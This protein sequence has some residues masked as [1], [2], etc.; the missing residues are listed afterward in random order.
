MR[1]VP[2]PTEPSE[3]GKNPSDSEAGRILSA[4]PHV[5][6]RSGGHLVQGEVQGQELDQD[7]QGA[8]TA[9]P[10]GLPPQT[11]DCP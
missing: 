1:N 7:A 6:D 8:K 11:G 9:V 10:K 5:Q 4:C 2:N 3:E